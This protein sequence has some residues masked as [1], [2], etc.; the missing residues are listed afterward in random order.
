MSRLFQT[1]KTGDR[2]VYSE[3]VIDVF[4]PLYVIEE[5]LDEDLWVPSTVVFTDP[6]DAKE[7]LASSTVK[8]EGLRITLYQKVK[9]G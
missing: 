9:N 8:S 5:R 2:P 1:R 3:K 6:A 4:N 7:Y